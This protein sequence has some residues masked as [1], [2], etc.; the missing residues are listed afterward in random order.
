MKSMILVSGQCVIAKQLEE[1]ADPRIP[2]G[3]FPKIV[4]PAM[5]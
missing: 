1:I 4:V 2:G 5:G 3:V